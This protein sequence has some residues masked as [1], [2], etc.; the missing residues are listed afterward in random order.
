[1]QFHVYGFFMAHRYC[2]GY[3]LTM[4]TVTSVVHVHLKIIFLYI[5]VYLAS[6]LANVHAHCII[7]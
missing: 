7:Q 1:M 2:H 4:E 6:H 3:F 5:Y